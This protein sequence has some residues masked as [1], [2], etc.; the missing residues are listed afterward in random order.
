MFSG[1]GSFQSSWA[2]LV[3]EARLKSGSLITADYAL[4]QGKDVYAVPGIFP[5]G[6]DPRPFRQS[7]SGLQPADQSG[8]K[9]VFCSRIGPLKP[10]LRLQPRTLGN[11]ITN[12][13]YE[14]F[15]KNDLTLEKTESMVYST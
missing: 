15:R 5:I 9:D 10:G 1:T 11:S 7:P 2:V 14:N 13:N 6:S 3:V 12:R 4:E 8:E